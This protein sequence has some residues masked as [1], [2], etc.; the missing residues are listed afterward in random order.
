MNH[1]NPDKTGVKYKLNKVMGKLNGCVEKIKPK[2]SPVI[3]NI[4]SLNCV[5]TCVSNSEKCD[6]KQKSNKKTINELNKGKLNH[7]CYTWH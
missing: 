4:S 1:N 3:G 2:L 7:F 6:S 5:K